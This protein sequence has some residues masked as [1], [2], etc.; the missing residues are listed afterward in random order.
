MSAS[1]DEAVADLT[2]AL[3][4]QIR[5]AA[6]SRTALRIIGG[7][8]KRFYGRQ[9]AGET[10]DLSGHSGIVAYD[11]SELVITA[12]SGTQLAEI[13][14][15]LAAH[16]Q[17]LG[18]EPPRLGWAS[19]IGGV[20]AAG[21]A[22]PA[23]PF[24]GAVRDSV[25]GAVILDGRGRRLAFGGQ[26]FKN[27][28]G[29]DAFRLQAG[30]L[31]AL[32]VIVEVSLRVR[33]APRRELALAFELASDAARAR[34]TELLRRPTSL[35]GAFY[36]GKRLRLRLSGGEAGVAALAGELGGETEPL[37]VWDDIRDHRHP[38]LASEPRLWRLSLPQSAP[39]PAVGEVLAWDWAGAQV[40][41]RSEA[42]PAA[43][44]DAAE[45]VGGH[46]TLFRGA[47][48][49][50]AVFQPLA[51]AIF[52]LHQRLKAVFDPAGILNPGRLYEGL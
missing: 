34:M 40:W 29:F 28:A 27:V 46:A 25:L 14:A 20:V 38:A 51:P 33:P 50:E 10:L 31:G 16:R 30:A 26:V 22:G 13:E 2:G 15:R 4:E 17:R 1:V 5:R 44:F 21:L 32:G 18:F 45:V 11:P 24:A 49:G 36:D 52:A 7:D 37:A 9:V 6:D 35:S 48:P 39:V 3:A 47:R 43:I 41:L 12:R 8:T 19:T 23:R 42:P